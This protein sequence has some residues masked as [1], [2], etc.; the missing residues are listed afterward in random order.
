MFDYVMCIEFG[1]ILAVRTLELY[2]GATLFSIVV[3]GNHK[4]QKNDPSFDEF[5]GLNIIT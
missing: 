3:H 5:C 1:N 4:Q 2:V